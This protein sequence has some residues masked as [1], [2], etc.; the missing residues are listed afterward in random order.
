MDDLL[1]NAMES[2]NLV[3]VHF[4]HSFQCDRHAGG[5]GM[6]LF[7]EFVY[8]DA[9]SIVTLRFRQLSDQITC[10]GSEGTSWG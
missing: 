10:Q 1:G 4:C 7:R 8:K 6:D 2:E 3:L 9:D 5:N